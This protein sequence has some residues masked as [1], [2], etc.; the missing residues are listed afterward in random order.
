MTDPIANDTASSPL[1]RAPKFAWGH[2][3]WAITGLIVLGVGLSLSIARTVIQYQPPGPHVPGRQGLC[4]FHN[5]IYFPSSAVMQGTSPYGDDYASSYPVARQIPFFSPSILVLHAPFTML[6]MRVAE[7]LYYLMTIGCILAIAI[8]VASQLGE[9]VRWDIAIWIAAALVFSRGGH[10]TLYNGYFTFELVLATLV[11]IHFADRKPWISA[12]A[13]VLVSAKPTYILPLGFLM[14]ARGN[15]KA[16]VRGAVLSIVAAALPM[17]WMAYH[18][19]SGDV[20][21]GMEIIRQDIAGAQELHRSQVDESPLYSWTRVDLLAI[22]AKWTGDDPQELTHLGVMGVILAPV[23]WVLF[24]LK[25]RDLDDGLVGVAGALILTTILVS[26]YHQS[27]DAV[28]LIAPLAGICWA[29]RFGSLPQCSTDVEATSQPRQEVLSCEL[30]GQ[31]EDHPPMQWS[32]LPVFL[33]A[34]LI[35][36]MAVPL[37]NYVSTRVVLRRVLRVKMSIGDSVAESVKD[38]SENVTFLSKLL[39]SLNGAALVIILLILVAY[40]LRKIASQ[41]LTR[42]TSLQSDSMAK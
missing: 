37:Y 11:A 1:E 36:L 22:V 19:G 14:L 17:A 41:P 31:F 40:F 5:G 35:M 16:L 42:A 26:V 28:L 6:P 39:T 4:D 3:R 38:P 23:M 21:A 9:S 32:R 7:V 12:L 15:G 33:R 27:Y 10:I 24:Q 8:L 25:K 29:G 34:A 30:Q 18:E 20:M 13:L 2:R